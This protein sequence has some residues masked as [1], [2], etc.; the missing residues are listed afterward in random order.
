VAICAHAYQRPPWAPLSAGRTSRDR[1]PCSRR[2]A[3][4]LQV[5]LTPGGQGEV[6]VRRDPQHIALAISFAELAQLAA[7]A[8]HLVAA[9]EVQPDAV[10]ERL[11]GQAMA[12][13]PLVRNPRSSGSPITR[14]FTG[15]S[16]CSAGICC[17]AAISA[18]PACFRTYARCPAVIPLASSRAAQ[19]VALDPRGV[20]TL[21][22]LP[23]LIDHP[24][25]QAAAPPRPARRLIQAGHGEP[26]HHRHRRPGVPDGPVEQPL[27]LIRRRI[28]TCSAIVHPLRLGIWLIS[29]AAYLPACSHGSTRANHG[30]SS[31][32]SSARFRWPSPAPILAAAAASA[33]AVFTNA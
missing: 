11:G 15:S 2:A 18:C 26:A 4:S 3:A 17:R 20:L 25:R 19:V 33:L 10:S 21:L 32:S 23:G 24:D 5:S 30:L 16:R 28:P 12:S 7:A 6:K 31:S 9:H 29:A 27:G 1:L 14:D 13:C 8:V 22:D